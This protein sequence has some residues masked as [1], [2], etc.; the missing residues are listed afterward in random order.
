MAQVKV[1]KADLDEILFENREK[2]Y[3]GYVLRKNSEYYLALAL[4]IMFTIITLGAVGPLIYNKLHAYIDTKTTTGTIL[5][6]ETPPVN[7]EKKKEVAVIPPPPPPKQKEQAA[8]PAQAIEK[9]AVK[10]AVPKPPT[11][12]KEEAE[13]HTVKETESKPTGI[14]DENG[15]KPDNL[16]VP[17]L[18]NEPK[19]PTTGPATIHEP[20]TI[21]AKLPEPAK[22]TP[23]EPLPTDF[24]VATKPKEVNLND[25]QK[26]IGYPKV[27]VELG[28]EETIIFRVLI[29]ENG[30]YVRHLPA[31][32]KANEILVRAVEEHISEVKFTPAIQNKKPIKFWVNVPFVFQLH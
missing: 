23:K 20:P 14:K 5:T 8:P 18:P 6:F 12:V 31:S 29:D 25:I 3:G 7:S 28:I 19:D 22:E 30:D 11:E 24:I 17:T 2:R 26:R 21:P 9:V 16:N 15:A 13:I 27:A 4:L 10:V 1:I 32:K